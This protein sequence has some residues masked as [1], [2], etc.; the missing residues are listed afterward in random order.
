MQENREK[1]NMKRKSEPY[2]CQ[3]IDETSTHN[4]FLVHR[5]QSDKSLYSY[6]VP[7][8]NEGIRGQL[9]SPTTWNRL[10]FNDE[11]RCVTHL[12]KAFKPKRY[13]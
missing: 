13:A 7:W 8:T 1:T 10:T 2:M 4:K 3:R 11:A 12:L 6:L 5:T 9:M